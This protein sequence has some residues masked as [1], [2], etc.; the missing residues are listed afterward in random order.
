MIIFLYFEAEVKVNC[1][2]IPA[3]LFVIPRAVEGSGQYVQDLPC[4]LCCIFNTK[5]RSYT[6]IMKFF[7][8]VITRLVRVIYRS[9]I[10]NYRDRRVR[11]D[12]SSSPRPLSSSPEFFVKKIV[13]GS[14]YYWQTFSLGYLLNFLTRR[15]QRPQSFTKVFYSPSFELSSGGSGNKV[16]SYRFGK[17]A[18]G[19]AL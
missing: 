7:Y 19:K 2:V 8:A 3:S 10:F 14:G 9:I 4:G 5:T 11:R 18:T 15:T 13:R 16:L 12:I 6:K 1:A 17:T